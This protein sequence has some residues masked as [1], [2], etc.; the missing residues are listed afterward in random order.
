MIVE[1]PEKIFRKAVEYV[2]T[3]DL[4]D[5]WTYRGEVLDKPKHNALAYDRVPKGNVILFDINTDE[6]R[7][8]SYEEKAAEAARIGLEVVPLLYSGMVG[9]ADDVRGFL[10]R[11]SIL[12]GQ[13]IEGVVIKN[14]SR[15]GKDKKAL[16]GKYVSEAYKE[17][18][19]KSWGEAN[20]HQGDVIIRL[21]GMFKT[22]ARWNKA[23]IHLEE[24]GELENSPRDIGKLIAEV[25]EDIKKECSEE[26]RDVCFKWAIEPVLRGSVAG[27][28]EYYKQRLLESQ[29]T[30]KEPPNA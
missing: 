17:V 28:P 13:K 11:T 10:E 16:M 5:G 4:R 26:I 2:A 21:I 22:P 6:E 23:V 12:G 29:F 7:Y 3:L 20:P 9:S 15:F 14:Y 27:L 8:L 24:K 1:S 25:K 18:H 19:R 30:G